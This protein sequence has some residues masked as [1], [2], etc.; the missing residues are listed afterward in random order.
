MI[1]E[2]EWSSVLNTCR[3]QSWWV[4]VMSGKCS[5]VWVYSNCHTGVSWRAYAWHSNWKPML[6]GQWKLDP[7]KFNSR[8]VNRCVVHANNCS[9]TLEGVGCLAGRYSADLFEL[10]DE[11]RIFLSET[12]ILTTLHGKLRKAT[13]CWA[14]TSHLVEIGF[15]SVQVIL[16]VTH[17]KEKHS[18]LA[19][20]SWSSKG[21]P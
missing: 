11:M 7:L 18:E 8:F 14:V 21:Y 3:C 19:P 20:N 9:W 12:S 13:L 4:S 6:I 1:S 10:H 2:L 15:D 5:G 16:L 17:V